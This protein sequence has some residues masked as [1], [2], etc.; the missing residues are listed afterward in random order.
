MV[1]NMAETNTIV[2]L[3][4]SKCAKRDAEI[5]SAL[6][7]KPHA[8]RHRGTTYIEVGNTY[9]LR[10]SSRQRWAKNSTFSGPCNLGDLHTISA[11]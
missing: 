10:Q 9:G 11:G 2:W 4:P 3:P 1:A 7:E 8:D 6:K 5:Q